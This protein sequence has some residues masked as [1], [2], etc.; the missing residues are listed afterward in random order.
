MFETA[1]HPNAY[2]VEP[3]RKFTAAD[4]GHFTL[5]FLLLLNSGELLFNS[6]TCALYDWWNKVMFYGAL[7]WMVYLVITLVIQFRNQGTRL[8][9]SYIDWFYL[10]FHIVMWVW[11]YSILDRTNGTCAPRWHFWATI[12]WILG[13]FAV[14]CIAAMLIMCTLRMINAK[15]GAKREELALNSSRHGDYDVLDQSAL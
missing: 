7:V 1:S 9:L 13:W 2:D 3:R 14:A 6:T 12:Y 15:T 11:D 5:T 8:F 4:A 10:L